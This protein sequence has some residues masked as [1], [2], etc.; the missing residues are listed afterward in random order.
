[1]GENPDPS[2][3]M[4]SMETAA[5]DTK[6]AAN[7][8]PKSV[9]STKTLDN[10]KADPDLNIGN[11]NYLL[12]TN[13]FNTKVIAFG[14]P[15]FII[16]YIATVGV[17][18]LYLINIMYM[19]YY[20]PNIE[21]EDYKKKRK[22]LNYY[23]SLTVVSPFKM[24]K[25]NSY[26]KE[27]NIYQTLTSNPKD[28]Y[29]NSNKQISASN[30][31]SKMEDTNGVIT[32]EE[33]KKHNVFLGLS[34][35]SYLYMAI[36]FTI[37]VFLIIDGYLNTFIFSLF[38]STVQI[39]SDYVIPPNNPY[40]NP[41]C[42]QKVSLQDPTLFSAAG[43]YNLYNPY[44][45][46]ASGAYYFTRLGLMSYVFLIPFFTIIFFIIFKVDNY[47][48]KKNKFVGFI[49]LFLMF[50]PLIFTIITRASFPNKFNLFDELQK[51][52]IS[53]DYPYIEFMKNT[54]SNKMLYVFMYLSIIFIFVYYYFCHFMIL[55]NT[56]KAKFILTLFLLL[57]SLI[58]V[59]LML[60]PLS[61]VFSPKDY[62]PSDSK[63]IDNI[64]N[65]IGENKS[66]SNLFQLLV[67]YNF[68]CFA[69]NK[70]S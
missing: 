5:S 29:K 53:H 26:D 3:A 12:D 56:P 31:L 60:T 13:H 16:C 41:R 65:H 4:S 19:Q 30:Q 63:T 62:I 23:R 7:S 50:Y 46:Y 42:I 61:V 69:R 52:V 68:P 11:I 59:T 1:M 25:L 47:D 18:F 45:P 28:L 43:G 17:S 58:P 44:N 38:S 37:P 51:F 36:A 70:S 8:A 27:T 6:N 20:F 2:S 64:N 15:I 24:F 22:L 49:L 48:L 55:P 14:I 33:M 32:S 9:Q 57:F 34:N 54:Y 67:K 66:V 35:M 39:N 10:S 21:N 40:E